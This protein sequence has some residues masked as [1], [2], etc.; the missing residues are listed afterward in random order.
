MVL[1]ILGTS[2]KIEHPTYVVSKIF[3]ILGFITYLAVLP[4]NPHEHL[5]RNIKFLLLVRFFCSSLFYSLITF[6]MGSFNFHADSH[7]ADS[8]VAI[9]FTMLVA[10][11]VRTDINRI[12]KYFYQ[13]IYIQVSLMGITQLLFFKFDFK[14][15]IFELGLVGSLHLFY[16]FLKRRADQE[17]EHIKASISKQS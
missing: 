6:S 5:K 8:L 13:L 3:V 4:A 17:N 2:L 14:E 16:Q 15:I 10:L 1:L 9:I 11:F 7:R 12:K